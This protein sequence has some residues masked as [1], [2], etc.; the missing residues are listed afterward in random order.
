MKSDDIL[1]KI[2]FVLEERAKLEEGT[3]PFVIFGRFGV[4]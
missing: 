4:R 3:L 2:N 1:Q